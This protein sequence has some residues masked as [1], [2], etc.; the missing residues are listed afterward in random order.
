MNFSSRLNKKLNVDPTDVESAVKITSGLSVLGVL[1]RLELT[2]LDPGN[3]L[4]YRKGV[5]AGICNYLTTSYEKSGLKV[6]LVGRSNTVVHG[7]I[8]NSRN[9]VVYDH[10]GN[11]GDAEYSFEN[12]TYTNSSFSGTSDKF[13]IVAECSV[14]ELLDGRREQ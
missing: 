3:P 6:V 4:S 13:N 11:T 10:F 8:V 9:K 2:L 1:N 14:E 5:Y 12:Q 7:I